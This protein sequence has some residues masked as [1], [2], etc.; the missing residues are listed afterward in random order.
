LLPGA[1]RLLLPTGQL[2]GNP[3]TAGKFTIRAATSR[4]AALD[5][6]TLVD[7]IRLDHFR[8][9]AIGSAGG[10][11]TAKRSLGRPGQGSLTSWKKDWA[12]Y[13]SS[14]KT[15]SNHSD[16]V[17]YE[18]GIQPPWD[19]DIAVCI[20]LNDPFL[21]HH[22]P[23]NCVVYTGTRQRHVLGWYQRVPEGC[24]PTYHI[25]T[26][27]VSW[28]LIGPVAFCQQDCSMQDFLSQD[29]QSMNFRKT[30]R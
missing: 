1:A 7:V 11:E 5:V 25:E 15:W 8:G 17:A 13:R 23:V 26:E 19:E 20:C 29:N 27:A 2:W 22:W 28:D 21:P 3:Y 24:L 18:R 30:Q 6:L 4:A 14:L 10:S 12:A 16:A 9:F